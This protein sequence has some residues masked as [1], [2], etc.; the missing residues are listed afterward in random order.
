MSKI[1]DEYIAEREKA[2][3]KAEHIGKISKMIQKGYTKESILDLDY[4]E[5]EYLEAEKSL[6]TTV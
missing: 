3:L 5:E 6:L 2:W 1:M 4:T